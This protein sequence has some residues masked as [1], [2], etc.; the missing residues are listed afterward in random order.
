MGG[1][2]DP[3]HLGHL[4]LGEHTY[5]QLGLDSV[6]FM[7]SGRPP[8]KRNREGCASDIQRAEMV[9]LAVQGNPHFTVSMME[10]EEE[11][12]TYTFHTLERLASE[13]PDTH[14][15]FIIGADSLRDFPTWREPQRICRV[16]TLVCASRGETADAELDRLIDATR[17]R[18]EADIVRLDTPLI[19]ISSSELRKRAASGQSIRYYVPDAV[20]EYISSQQIYRHFSVD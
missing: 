4:I 10:M 12:Y 3:I 16:C 6:C 18:Y 7:P 2:F 13:N 14:Y 15:Y 20:R 1:T 17:Q 11:G 8:H 19:D 9:R 5:G